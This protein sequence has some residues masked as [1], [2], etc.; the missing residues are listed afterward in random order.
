M[1]PSYVATRAPREESQSGP[2]HQ[3][4]RARP[5]FRRCPAPR[6]PSGLNTTTPGPEGRSQRGLGPRRQ[7]GELNALVRPSPIIS[8]AFSLWLSSSVMDVSFERLS[9]S[10]KPRRPGEG[11][12]P[13][14]PPPELPGPKGR[15][16][17]FQYSAEGPLDRRPPF[18]HRIRGTR[19]PV[20]L[21]LAPNFACSDVPAV[22]AQPDIC[23]GQEEWHILPSPQ[24]ALAAV[25]M[26]VLTPTSSE[27]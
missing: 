16:Q 24:R 13:S 5:V 6:R 7:P 1:P 9:T 8:R 25:T 10:P 14:L 15:S 17:V 18:G 3:R 22:A 20:G 26:E 11:F 19:R 4:R 2:R 21:Q 23:T 12:Q 27:R